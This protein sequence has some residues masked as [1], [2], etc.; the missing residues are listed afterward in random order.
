MILSLRGQLLSTSKVYDKIRKVLLARPLVRVA[1][2]QT[3]R[4]TFM[5]S[6]TAITRH[7]ESKFSEP[8]DQH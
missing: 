2:E 6:Y 5:L 3:K 8:N 1:A 4:Y 7:K